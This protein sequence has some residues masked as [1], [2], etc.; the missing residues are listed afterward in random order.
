M[1]VSPCRWGEQR[2]CLPFPD[3]DVGGEASAGVVFTLQRAAPPPCVACLLQMAVSSRTTQCRAPGWQVSL[4]PPRHTWPGT[5]GGTG[6]SGHCG[7]WGPLLLPH[8]AGRA[9]VHSLPSVLT[10]WLPIR[11]GTQPQPGH[12][13]PGT[14][15]SCALV[16]MGLSSGLSAPGSC[17]SEVNEVLTGK[18]ASEA[19]N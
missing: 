15:S 11:A 6:P 1:D 19:K 9:R 12:P 4:P 17:H 8:P 5:R 14:S 16:S 13:T 18:V 7:D 2:I 10:A 3:V